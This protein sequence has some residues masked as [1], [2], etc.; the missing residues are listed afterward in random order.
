MYSPAGEQLAALEITVELLVAGRKM[1]LAMLAPK[2]NAEEGRNASIIHEP[3]AAVLSTSR[4]LVSLVINLGSNG[5][6]GQADICEYTYVFQL[7]TVI[8][9]LLLL[10]GRM[11]LAVLLSARGDGDSKQV[12]DAEAAVQAVAVLLSHLAVTLPIT[13]GAS[14]V[15]NETCRGE[16]RVFAASNLPVCRVILPASQ[17]RTSLHPRYAWYRPINY[18]SGRL[19]PPQPDSAESENFSLF[20]TPLSVEPGMPNPE[21]VRAAPP[22]ASTAYLGP[23]LG[24]GPADID[25][26]SLFMDLQGID[27]TYDAVHMASQ[28]MAGFRP[29]SG[30]NE[31]GEASEADFAWFLLGGNMVGGNVGG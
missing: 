7:T 4:Q 31:G 21:F 14:E 26:N 16:I 27:S 18:R 13:V 28:G 23:T 12:A 19:A 11:I 6:L 3:R 25:P 17:R 29:M 9:Y 2:L 24:V 15:F 20:D 5:L 22:A 8:A 10:A 1:Q 30:G